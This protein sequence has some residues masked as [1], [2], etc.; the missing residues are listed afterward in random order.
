MHFFLEKGKVGNGILPCD[1][2]C[3]VVVECACQRPSL[4]SRITESRTDVILANFS[5]NLLERMSLV[6]V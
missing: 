4:P 1:F 2:R 6:F 3:L 5:W